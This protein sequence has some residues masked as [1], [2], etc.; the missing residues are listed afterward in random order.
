MQRYLEYAL[1]ILI[2]PPKVLKPNYLQR[3]N[4]ITQEKC[5]LTKRLKRGDKVNQGASL[6]VANPGTLQPPVH[7][8]GGH[9][10]GNGRGIFLNKARTFVVWVGEE[11]HL[12]IISIQ[13][14]GGLAE[15]F[16][17]LA[18]AVETL[19]RHLHFARDDSLGFLTFCPSNLGTTLRAS[20]H[21]KLPH[22]VSEGRLDV[23][24]AENNLQV[25][26]TGG[27]HTQTVGGVVDL[28]NTRRL[29]ATELDIVAEMF[30]AVKKIIQLEKSITGNL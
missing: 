5:K 21:L 16:D 8:E 10:R 3:K 1:R 6:G 11:D 27:E 4:S 17:R 2:C 9:T 18:E 7:E 15:V 23:V 30:E 24:A 20:V 28:S 12:R 14:G 13:Q 29:G 25:R 19:S 26:G 22:L